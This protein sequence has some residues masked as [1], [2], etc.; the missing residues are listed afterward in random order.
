ML[1]TPKEEPKQEFKKST[2]KIPKL[3]SLKEELNAPVKEEEKPVTDTSIRNEFSISNLKNYWNEYA[4]KMKRDKRDIEYVILSNRDLVVDENF[5]VKF[6]L[7]NNIQMDQLNNFKTEL[8]E[9]LRRSLKNNLILV[10]ASMSA[11][12]T[13]KIIYTSDDKLKHLAQKYPI[14]EDLKKRL[15][16]DTDF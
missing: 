8:T 1:N 11:M 6:T 5:T 15:G 2:F 14:V 10:E 12:E 3:T 4:A 16:L 9:Y 7:D 13:K